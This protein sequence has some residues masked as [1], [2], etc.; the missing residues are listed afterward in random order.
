MRFDTIDPFP[1]P[2]DLSQFFSKTEPAPPPPPMSDAER[3]RQ[4]LQ[5]RQDASLLDPCTVDYA[6]V[7]ALAAAVEDA[8]VAGQMRASRSTHG[9]TI[10]FEQ[11]LREALRG[12]R[13]NHVNGQPVTKA[14]AVEALQQR[15]RLR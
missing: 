3:K 11:V 6:I 12:I 14:A 1:K 4:E 8:D 7:A 13:G 9:L 5:A 15:L 10:N 2:T